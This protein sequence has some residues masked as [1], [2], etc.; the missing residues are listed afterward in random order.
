MLRLRRWE[1]WNVSISHV[2]HELPGPRGSFLVA[3]D[4]LGHELNGF[5]NSCRV[6]GVGIVRG[7]EVEDFGRVN[8]TI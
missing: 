2:S 4:S 3:K 1:V 5:L 7:R 6:E 8:Q